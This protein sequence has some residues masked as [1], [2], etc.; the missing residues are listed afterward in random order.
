MAGEPKRNPLSLTT[1]IKSRKSSKEA[2]PCLRHRCL[3]DQ[4]VPKLRNGKEIKRNSNRK[5]ASLNRNRLRPR[6]SMTTSSRKRVKLDDT[7]FRQF[8]KKTL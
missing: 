6:K 5:P 4:E 2:S 8:I 3:Q 7:L 1:Q